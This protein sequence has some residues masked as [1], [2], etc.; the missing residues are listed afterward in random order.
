[1]QIMSTD[2]PPFISLASQGAIPATRDL[3]STDQPPKQQTQERLQALGSGEALAPLDFWRV[4]QLLDAG[5]VT[6]IS[7]ARAAA[8][9]TTPEQKDEIERLSEKSKDVILMLATADFWAA[10]RVSGAAWSDT[11]GIAASSV[12]MVPPSNPPKPAWRH[13][14]AAVPR[15]DY[16]ASLVELAQTMGKAPPNTPDLVRA[17]AGM[18]HI[19]LPLAL[20]MHDAPK[21]WSRTCLVIDVVQAVVSVAVHRLKHLLLVPRPDDSIAFPGLSVKPLIPTP[22][23]TAYPSGHAALMFALSTVLG[24]VVD[25]KGSQQAQ[26]DALAYE[27]AINRERAGLHTHLDTMAGVTLGQEIARWMIDAVTHPAFGPWS[28]VYAA[29]AN[30]WFR[31]PSV[32]AG[33]AAQNPAGA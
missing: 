2:Q 21:Q 19:F 15:D 7:A 17:Q 14:L 30:E 22:R 18:P 13:D 12:S 10:T 20:G 3:L 11:A 31:E 25:A 26:L 1:M 27:I 24:S 33:S 8:Y 29:A 23:Y 6:Q 9:P 28:A 4:R 32:A 16:L 5:D